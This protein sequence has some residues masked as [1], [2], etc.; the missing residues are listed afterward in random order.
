M[1]SLLAFYSLL[2]GFCLFWV[3]AL[4]LAGS[5]ACQQGARRFVFIMDRIKLAH[6]SYLL[7][8]YICY[9]LYTIRI[10]PVGILRDMY[11]LFFLQM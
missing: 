6:L 5:S 10:A 3:T 1:K 4:C 8:F 9:S 7:L 11:S 2:C